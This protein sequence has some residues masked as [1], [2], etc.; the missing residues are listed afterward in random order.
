MDEKT[1]AIKKEYIKEIN[2][3]LEQC[4]DITLIDLICRILIK[5]ENSRHEG[6]HSKAEKQA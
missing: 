4:E 5:S 1:K 6:G 2:A 3:L